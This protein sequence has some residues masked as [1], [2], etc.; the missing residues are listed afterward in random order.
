MALHVGEEREV[1]LVITISFSLV[2]NKS[3][4]PRERGL[5]LI[6]HLL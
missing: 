5:M 2:V 4:W 1:A 6:R 3:L